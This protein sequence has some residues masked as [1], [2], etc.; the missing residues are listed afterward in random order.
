MKSLALLLFS[1]LTV[2]F[3]E[4]QYNP[5]NVAKKPRQLY[6][7][8]MQRVDDGNIAS[9]LGM[10]LQ[11]VQ[12]DPNFVDAH[13]S[14]GAIYG[15]LKNYR[16]AVQYFEKAFAVDASYTMDYRLQYSIQLAGLGEFQKALDA[17]NELL[18]KKPP[19]NPTSLESAMKRKSS[20]EF[21]VNFAK[22]TS[23]ADWVFAPR[24]LGPGV[25]SAESEYFPSLTIDG[26]ALI[27]T[28]RVG[29][30]N[31]DFYVSEAGPDEW[32]PASPIEGINTPQNEAGQQVSADGKWLVFTAN[33]MPGGF[34]N[35]DLYISFLEKNGW[36]S[37]LNLGGT[38]NS[39]WW[40]SQPCLSPD[41]KD[42]YFASR[43]YGGLGGSDIYVSRLQPNGRWSEPENLGP[44][45]NTPGDDQCPFIHADNQTL[46][47][48]SNG[49]PGYGG[50][51]LFFVRKDPKKGWTRPMNLGYPINTIHDEGTLFV[52]ADGT[53]AYYASD[54][55]D[56]RGGHD[57]YRFELPLFARPIRTLWVR[58]KV[59]DQRTGAPLQS[60]L[61]LVDLSSGNRVH[62]VHTDQAGEYLV[63]LPIGKDYAFN[64]NRKGYL[65]YSDQFLFAGREPDSTYNLDIA[66]SP[67]EANASIVLK[68]IF[69][70]VNQYE[71]KQT[72]QVELDRLVAL[73]QE[74]PQLRIEISGHTDNVGK[75]ADNLTLSVNRAK[76]VV[77]Y[78]VSK[79]IAANRLIPKGYG[80][81]KPVADNNTEEGRARNRRTEMKVIS[82]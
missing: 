72:S 79:G 21:A 50:N 32:K 54:R 58:G 65:F 44:G 82:P 13:L 18:A 3:A 34:G 33:N 24:N 45:I 15:H 38:V 51:D 70:D 37:P 64:V 5:G 4:A 16:A 61:E 14:L 17:V 20:Y 55:E 31:E 25:N 39:E 66:L 12:L 62:L 53:T 69:F 68:N 76:S 11:A 63:T 8:A 22:E 35:F 56:S 75:P 78:L 71:L 29:N 42:L 47:F 41:K 30:R 67:I 74:N 49:W 23:L 2:A 60:A 28:R 46:Y 6:E 81:A 59:T 52:T 73:L 40:D 10:L 7:Q 57:V 43:R 27:F 80:E 48:V 9:A 19:K 77:Q 36:T 26:Q 1:L